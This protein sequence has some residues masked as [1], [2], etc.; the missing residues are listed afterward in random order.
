MPSVPAAVTPASAT[1][2]EGEGRAR[3]QVA[4]A[5]APQASAR[6]AGLSVEPP[7]AVVRV[8]TLDVAS[9]PRAAWQVAAEPAATVGDP[10]LGS[11]PESPN[12]APARPPRDLTWRPVREALSVASVIAGS[13]RG[14]NTALR[15]IDRSLA[16]RWTA[17]GSG[18]QWLTYDLG[19]QQEIRAVSV[20]WYGPAGTRADLSVAVSV[21]GSRFEEVDAGMI[22]GRGTHTTLRAF[23]P[24]SARYVRLTC[25]QAPGA[26]ALSIF[27]V[28]IHG[29]AEVCQATR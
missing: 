7:A 28:G 2:W 16:T 8:A 17:A 26:A 29:A 13:A 19:R 6:Q 24:V 3:T 18:P 11:R 14:V 22:K 5:A 9:D 27:E 10:Q 20:V 25:T 15:T 21:D 23:M 1:G 12:P 4:G